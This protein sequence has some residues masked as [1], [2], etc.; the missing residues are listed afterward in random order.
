MFDLSN[1]IVS[2]KLSSNDHNKSFDDVRLTVNIQKTTNNLWQ[3]RWIDFLDID[4]NVFLKIVS[5]KMKNQV[6]N[7]VESITN[8]NK[9]KLIS[10]F[11][12]F[13]EI[14]DFFWLVAVRLTADSLYFLNL[15]CLYCSFNV[16]EMNIGFLTFYSV[17]NLRIYVT[18]G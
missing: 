14:L 4:F 17:I 6:M 16:F 3:S 1:K 12:F 8:N 15:V 10:Q 18:V 7:K 11:L 5:V 9:R 13:E 2:G